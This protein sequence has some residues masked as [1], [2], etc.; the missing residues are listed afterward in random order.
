MTTGRDVFEILARENARMLRAFL[1]GLA[2]DAATADDLFQEALVVAWRKLDQ[3][4]RAR[5]FGPW[6]RGIAARLALD[7]RR[8]EARHGMVLCDEATLA[9]L[10]DRFARVDRIPADTW[11]EKTAALRACLE[12]LLPEDREVIALRYE[13]DRSCEEIAARLGQGLEWAKKRLQ[14]ARERVGLCVEG[15]LA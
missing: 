2:R 12:D 6:L 4:D 10:E 15:K 11:E 13:Q 9:L 5:P 1:L 8:S 14:R 7:R 3:Y